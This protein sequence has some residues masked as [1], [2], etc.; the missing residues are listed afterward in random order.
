MQL[1]AIADYL[2]GVRLAEYSQVYIEVKQVISACRDGKVW[3]S[4][5][6]SHAL[7]RLVLESQLCSRPS[8]IQL[9]KGIKNETEIKGMRMCQVLGEFHCEGHCSSFFRYCQIRDSAALCEYLYWLEREVGFKQWHKP[10]YSVFVLLGAQR[11][12]G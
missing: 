12:T 6:S 10:S 8:P 4:E 5:D 7:V 1:P 3:I 11:R 9:L 2:K